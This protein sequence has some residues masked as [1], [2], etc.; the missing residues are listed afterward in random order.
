MGSCVSG[1]L[2]SG[3]GEDVWDEAEVAVVTEG[4]GGDVA[5][6]GFGEVWREGG[7]GWEEEFVGSGGVFDACPDVVASVELEERFEEV[8][9]FYASVGEGFGAAPEKSGGP[10]AG[11]WGGH[12]H[13]HFHAG[14][15]GGVVVHADGAVVHDGCG[16]ALLVFGGVEGFGADDVGDGILRG[17]IL[18]GYE[19]DA[20]GVAVD[21]EAVG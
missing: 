9:V 5:D 4:V 18:C 11:G 7:A 1:E 17:P 12:V 20:G 8:A 19:R 10:V 6:W 13:I 14:H 15:A 21:G 3:G 16:L 2:G